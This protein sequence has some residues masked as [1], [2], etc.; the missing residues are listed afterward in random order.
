M[1][2]FFYNYPFLYFKLL[3]YNP[4]AISV[5]L[6][7]LYYIKAPPAPDDHEHLVEFKNRFAVKHCS[8]CNL[9]W[10]RDVNAAR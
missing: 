4:T 3:N 1:D 6:A 7:P 8:K 5:Q 10:N 9:L 2:N